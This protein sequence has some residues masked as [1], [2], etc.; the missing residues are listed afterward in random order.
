MK[1]AIDLLRAHAD[2]QD[3]AIALHRAAGHHAAADEVEEFVADC[4]NAIDQLEDELP[5]AAQAAALEHCRECGAALA[6]AFLR[7]P[8]AFA[9]DT[10]ELRIFDAVAALRSATTP[11]RMLRA[12]TGVH[13]ACGHAGNNPYGAAALEALYKSSAAL[14]TALD[15][16]LAKQ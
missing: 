8:A 3:K 7:E 14:A 1:R 2:V 10:R 13:Q 16:E 11:H 6:I 5:S 9:F 15:P 12:I 4:L